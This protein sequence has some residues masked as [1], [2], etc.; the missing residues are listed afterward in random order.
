MKCLRY[1][2]LLRVVGSSKQIYRC[3]FLISNQPR[4]KAATI[5]QGLRDEC[6][7]PSVVRLLETGCGLLG[8]T[9]GGSD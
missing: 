4:V 8:G 6:G 9:P 3:S 2:L 7:A 1:I 5:I